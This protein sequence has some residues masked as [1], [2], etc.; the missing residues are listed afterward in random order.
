MYG[1]KPVIGIAGGIGSGKSFVA[2]LFGQMGCL[3]IDSDEQVRAA[4]ADPRVRQTL[5]EWWGD[6]AFNPGDGEIN[7][8]FIGRKVFADEA[9]R[10]RLEALIHPIVHAARR[11]VMSA[12]AN[13]PQVVAFVW[14]T[15]LLFETGLHRECDA[16]VFV[17]APVAQRLQRVAGARGWDAAE[18]D[19]RQKLQ[20]PLDTKRQMSDYGVTNTAD[21]EYARGQ[22]RDVLSRILARSSRGPV[23]GRG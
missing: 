15:P 9:E 21:A 18:L 3:V 8:R 4:Y 10:K 20:W 14:D 6:E 23:P 12:A 13:D 5:R 1:G 17:E 22:V 19:R 7:R 16:L 2:R 11:E